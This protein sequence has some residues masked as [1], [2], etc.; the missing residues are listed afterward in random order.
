MR[1]A[2][3]GLLA[4]IAFRESAGAF[5]VLPQQMKGDLDKM[6]GEKKKEEP[7]IQAPAAPAPDLQ[8]M[9]EAAKAA[10]DKLQLQLREEAERKAR[11]DEAKARR[12]KMIGG[13]SLAAFL[14]LA[15]VLKRLL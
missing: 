3:L 8:A 13:G 12:L 15:A 2:I 5:A 1:A 9:L 4:L 10:R 14:I 11:E 6:Y 7:A